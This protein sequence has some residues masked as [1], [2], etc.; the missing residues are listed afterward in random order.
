MFAVGDIWESLYRTHN[1]NNDSDLEAEIRRE[2][3]KAYSELC[4]GTSWANMRDSIEYDLTAD[5][6]GKW[7]PADLIGVDGVANTEDMWTKGQK[8][9]SLNVHIQ[10]RMWYIDEYNRTP[11]LSGADIAIANGATTFT[12]TGITA[13]MVG[14]YIRINGQTDTHL[15]ISTTEIATPYYGDALTG[16]PFE[17]RPVGVQKIK[18]VTP[19]GLSDSGNP[20]IYFWRQPAQLYDASQLIQLPTSAMLEMATK[21][22]V[23]DIYRKIESKNGSQKDLYG[24]KGRYEG[25]LSRARATNP[26]FMLPVRPQNFG[27]NPATWGARP[28]R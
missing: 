7:L 6:D 19:S 3:R 8:P 17:V 11:L 13:A 4:A 14:E 12:A 2:C 15:L 21:I 24:S 28:R 20:V 25:E 22:K 5:V 10:S 16:N 9:G 1:A 23:F 18:L 27:G 26:D